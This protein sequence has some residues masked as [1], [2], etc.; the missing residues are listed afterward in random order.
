MTITEKQQDEES[1]TS[2]ASPPKDRYHFVYI[3]L[4]L[5]G[6][7][8]LMPWN[9]FINANDYFTNKLTVHGAADGI[10]PESTYVGY[11]LSYLGLA[12]QIP[13][14]LCSLLNVFVQSFAASG[15]FQRRI[16]GGILAETAI[17]ML[18][19][20]LAVM[21]T[22]AWTS[23][24]FYLTMGSVVVLNIANGVYQNTLW[25]IASKLPEYTNA[26]VLGTNFCGTFVSL[27]N[28]ITIAASPDS[29]MAAICYFSSALA[30]LLL[31]LLSYIALPYNRFFAYYVLD[32]QRLIDE[33][34]S[35]GEKVGVKSVRPIQLPR[36]PYWLV[37][38]SAWQQCLNVFLVF[39]VTLSVFPVITAG[40]E[41][42]RKDFLLG[43]VEW[44]SRYFTPICCFLV[45]NA[46]ALLGNF[47]PRWGQFPGPRHLWIAVVLRFL[48]IPF[49]LLANF[50]PASRASWLPVLVH[51]DEVVVGGMA[52]LGLTTGYFC[53]LCMIYAP[54]SVEAK[55]AGTAGMMAAASLVLGIFAGINFSSILAIL[56]KSS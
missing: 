55:H 51:S 49:F 33:S 8:I 44:T 5:H 36:P 41:P 17:I 42:V 27:V 43:S 4:I 34:P 31:C 3:T 52:L 56:V 9:M 7:G 11:F 16:L 29:R 32:E 37:I 28:W 39:F 12:A 50:A 30:M 13:N 26:V 14:V 21:N 46:T 54:R 10:S 40:I 24:F 48:F 20:A 23:T 2:S 35:G 19:I 22:S 15:R 47:L 53:S 6:I 45:F 38:K 18:T 1:E 25:G